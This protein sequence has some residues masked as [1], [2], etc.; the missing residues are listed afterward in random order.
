MFNFS[1]RCFHN[2]ANQIVLILLIEITDARLDG[3][4]SHLSRPTTI[5]KLGTILVSGERQ[6]AKH[7]ASV[8]LSRDISRENNIR[9]FGF[10][11]SPF[12]L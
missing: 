5:Q 2:T 8:K 12:F 11:K 7:A 4:N 1:N 3:F 10:K 6:D 9:A